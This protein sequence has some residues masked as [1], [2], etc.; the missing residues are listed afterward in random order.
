MYTYE[1]AKL[2]SSLHENV[3]M[4]KL[5][6]VLFESRNL[7]QLFNTICEL[8]ITVREHSTV[9][10][11]ILPPSQNILY[12]FLYVFQPH[13]KYIAFKC[14]ICASFGPNDAAGQIEMS[15][16]NQHRFNKVGL[17][18][19]FILFYVKSNNLSFCIVLS[20][21]FILLY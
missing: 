15:R 11:A 2:L 20:G 5:R 1:C 8:R 14:P 10:T 4:L 21:I 12:V 13:S 16:D 6:S 7:F 9:V 18:N 19:K 3:C 17:T